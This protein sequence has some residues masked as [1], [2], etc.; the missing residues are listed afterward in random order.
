MIIK[1]KKRNHKSLYLKLD[2]D[3]QVIF[4]H[5]TDEP[6]GLKELLKVILQVRIGFLIIHNCNK[7]L[8]IS[9][10]KLNII[11]F[12]RVYLR[13]V[14][15]SRAQGLIF[16]SPFTKNYFEERSLKRYNCYYVPFGEIGELPSKREKFEHLVLPGSMNSTKN[17]D[18]IYIRLKK[19][20]GNK[21]TVEFLGVATDEYGAFWQAKFEELSNPYVNVVTYSDYIEADLFDARLKVCDVIFVDFPEEIETLE[22]YIEV[23]GVSKE[24]G[25]P[26]LSYKYSKPVIVPNYYNLAY[27]KFKIK[28]DQIFC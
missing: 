22:G 26:W 13:R 20:K 2:K 23:Y 17:Y 12:L 25:A 7:W 27:P 4:N 3:Y 19:Y 15:L 14:I 10:T 8:E 5:V 6:Y 21:I 24:T 18:D 16:V 1:N 28:Q 9:R 11:E